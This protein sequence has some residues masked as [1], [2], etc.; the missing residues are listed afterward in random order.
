MSLLYRNPHTG[1][2][3]HQAGAK[4]IPHI[5]CNNNISLLILAAREYQPQHISGTGGSFSLVHKIY[6]PLKDI[7]SFSPREFK[8]TISNAKAAAKHAVSYISR[9]KNV[10][11]SC[12]AG[13]NRSGII[14]GLAL[15]ELT[16][17]SGKQVVYHIRKNRSRFALSNPLFAQVV[18][19][20]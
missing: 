14:S 2:E 20:S 13:W 18:A 16:G 17:A 7:T 12:L 6:I 5:L 15:V 19:N 11:S 1:G 4:E 8:K 3:L 9:G 10:L